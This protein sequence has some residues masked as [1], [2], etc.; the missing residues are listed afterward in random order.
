MPQQR[1]L[2]TGRRPGP[3][4]FW[5]PCAGGKQEVQEAVL[6]AGKQVVGAV[7]ACSAAVGMLET[8][9]GLG[10]GWGHRVGCGRFWPSVYT[11]TPYAPPCHCKASNGCSRVFQGRN[12]RPPGPLL[13][14][15]T[16]ARL[17][18]GW[19][20]HA[21]SVCSCAAHTR[22]ARATAPPRRLAAAAAASHSSPITRHTNQQ[23]WGRRGM[24]ARGRC[25][26]LGRAAAPN[27]RAYPGRAPWLAAALGLQHLACN[28]PRR[29]MHPDM[30][31][32][33]AAARLHQRHAD[34]CH[35]SPNPS[36]R[37]ACHSACHSNG[38]RSTGTP[39]GHS[40]LCW[41]LPMRQLQTTS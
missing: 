23:S 1:V 4:H 26:G 36:R 30:K 39:A 11:G 20:A 16:W 2:K 28:L 32:N 41:L 10:G 27:D 40:G 18:G 31:V 21:D 22:A 35:G 12:L 29:W 3:L 6:G 7:A 24:C 9:A 5:A 14:G 34:S 38:C 13:A 37:C 33:I 19:Q 8:G 17:L 25:L 15:H